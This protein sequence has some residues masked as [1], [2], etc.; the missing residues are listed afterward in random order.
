MDNYEEMLSRLMEEI[1]QLGAAYARLPGE[2]EQ[3]I[4]KR[5]DNL[6]A[7]RNSVE[8]EYNA[9]Q[10]KQAGTKQALGIVIAISIIILVFAAAYIFGQH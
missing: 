5:E 9:K 1:N 10:E 4:R 8:E 7:Y 3:L 6:Q 2:L